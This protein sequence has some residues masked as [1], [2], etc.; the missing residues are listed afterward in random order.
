MINFNFSIGRNRL[1]NYVE[2]DATGGFFYSINNAFKSLFSSGFPDNEKYEVIKNNPA[3]LYVFDFIAKNYSQMKI[4]EW[5]NDKLKEKNAIYTIQDKPNQWQSWTDLLYDYAFYYCLGNV[6]LY[7]QAATIYCL[8]PF[9]IKLTSKQEKD[10]SKLSFS[11]YGENTAKNIKKGT[12]EYYDGSSN[13]YQ[14]ELSN[15]HIISDLSNSVSGSWFKAN[16]KLDA[17]YQVVKNTDLTT[18]AK[19]INT[20]FTGKFIVAG[21]SDPQNISELPMSQEEQQSIRQSVRG[22]EQVIP[23]KSKVAIERFVS[24]LN[25][26]KLDESLIADIHIIGMMYG[27][28]KDVIGIALQGS[29]YEN[30]EKSF[31]AFV[32]YTLSPIARQMTDLIETLFDKEDLRASWEDMPFNQVFKTEKVANQKIELESLKIAQELGLDAKLITNKLNEIYGS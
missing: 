8:N 26:L 16:S 5:Q 19:Y 14:L 15:L 17:L 1:P 9:G 27:L 23:V 24:D 31:G 28:S 4:N 6:Y 25:N 32:D 3:V 10:F 18:K 21:Q 2:R 11:S 12:F 29:T 30:K 20:E 7:K 22:N 13:K